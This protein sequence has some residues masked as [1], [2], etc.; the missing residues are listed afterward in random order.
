MT[1]TCPVSDQSA[2]TAIHRV[3]ESL[4][5]RRIFNKIPMFGKTVLDY[6]CGHNADAEFLQDNGILAYGWDPHHN[7]NPSLVHFSGQYDVILCTYVLNVVGIK[8][9]R[10]ILKDIKRLLRPGG[11][12]YITVRADVETGVTS[13]GTYQRL[14]NL[15]RHYAIMWQNQSFTTYWATKEQL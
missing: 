9:Q 10:E 1:R 4:P 12:A 13:K 8:K 5:C 15:D 11:Q 2:K 3:R 14:V 7:D 6:G